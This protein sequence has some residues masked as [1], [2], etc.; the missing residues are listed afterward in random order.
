MTDIDIAQL[1]PDDWAAFR[2]LRL[3]ALAD[4]PDAFGSR[5]DDWAEAP[6][7]RWR[8][9]LQN[10][11]LNVIARLGDEAVGMA[12]GVL[13]DDGAELISMWVDPAVRGTGTARALIDAVV[14]WAHGL[15]RT[16]YLMVRSD[17][18]RAIAA[19]ERA[20]FVDLGVPEGHDGPPEHRMVHRGTAG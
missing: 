15:D 7:E 19:Y 12:S 14:D 17:N 2:D 9:R 8:D 1:A 11:Q 16:T 5:L 10:V 18:A 20:G 4:A 13:D 6:E 3:R